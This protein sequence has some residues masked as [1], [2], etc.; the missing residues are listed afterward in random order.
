MAKVAEEAG[1]YKQRNIRLRLSIW[2]LP[3]VFSS[4]RIRLLYHSNHWH[5]HNA[6][7]HA[8][9]VGGICFSLGLILCVV[10]GPISLLPQC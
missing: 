9:L 7:R 10:C 1:V 5:R 3:P 8:K 6:L 2:R 4:H